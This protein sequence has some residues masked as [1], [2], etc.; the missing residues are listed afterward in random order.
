MISFANGTGIRNCQRK[1][2]EQ[3]FDKYNHIHFFY[4]FFSS[5]TFFPRNFFQLFSLSQFFLFATRDHL[6]SKHREI[7]DNLNFKQINKKECGFKIINN[8]M[9]EVKQTGT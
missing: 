3:S 5:P 6:L 8:K 2:K 1:R 7:D 9:G 4:T